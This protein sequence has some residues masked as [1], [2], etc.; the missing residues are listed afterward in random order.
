MEAE[1][2][3]IEIIGSMSKVSAFIEMLSSKHI[4][5][6]HKLG[7]SGITVYNAMGC[8]VQS[9]SSEYMLDF[10][11]QPLR[12]L[13]KSTMIM[14]CET[15]KVKEVIEFL[16]KGILVTINTDNMTVSNT[17]LKR[18]Y[19][20][21]KETFQLSEEMLLQL[22]ENSV[23]AAFLP[24]KKKVKLEQKVK[25]EFLKWLSTERI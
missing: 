17:S 25:Q 5:E 21:L 13:P 20:L 24:L 18:E 16:K 8:G 23:E 7:I 9:G 15:S 14:I 12:L 6:I 19:Q 1:F 11:E 10:T 22:A 4:K 3:R 2:S